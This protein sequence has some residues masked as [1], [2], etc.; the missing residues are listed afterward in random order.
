MFRD[1]QI[2][3]SW[4]WDAKPRIVQCSASPGF[5][6]EP[7]SRPTSSRSHPLHT[8]QSVVEELHQHMP[9]AVLNLSQEHT[10]GPAW[11]PQPS[12]TSS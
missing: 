8:K 2:E 5:L 6:A 3:R 4:Q 1:L 9:I 12:L 10:I 11:M 7:H